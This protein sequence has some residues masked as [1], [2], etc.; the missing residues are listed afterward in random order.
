MLDVVRPSRNARH[1]LLYTSNGVINIKNE[2]WKND[3]SPIDESLGGWSAYYSKGYL[4]HLVLSKEYLGASIA[5]VHNLTFYLWLVREA[6]RRIKD[7]TYA[8]WM[9]DLLPAIG[10]RL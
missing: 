5:T 6:R 2:K 1:G 9:R 4:R 10:R 3:F 7:G 8:G